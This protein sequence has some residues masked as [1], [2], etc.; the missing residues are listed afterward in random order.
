MLIFLC[1]KMTS[2]LV[3]Q[4]SVQFNTVWGWPVGELGLR[5]SSRSWNAEWDSTRRAGKDW[6][7]NSFIKGDWTRA[8]PLSGDMEI[9]Q[10]PVLESYW[11]HASEIIVQQVGVWVKLMQSECEC[12]YMMKAMGGTRRPQV[13]HNAHYRGAPIP[14][15][16]HRQNYFRK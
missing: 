6:Q 1:M 8:T 2:C 7:S 15:V 9:N 3:I 14:F 12:R 5:I 10:P 16:K 13:W 11:S 4:C